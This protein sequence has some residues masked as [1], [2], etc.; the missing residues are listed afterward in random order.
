MTSKTNWSPTALTAGICLWSA[1][2]C[3]KECGPEG[4]IDHGEDG[5]NQ[6]TPVDDLQFVCQ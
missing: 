4:M 5:N 3:I 6:D 2:G 1:A